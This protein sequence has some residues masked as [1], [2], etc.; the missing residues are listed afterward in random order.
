MEIEANGKK[1]VKEVGSWFLTQMS[2]GWSWESLIQLLFKQR[3]GHFTRVRAVRRIVH[4]AI[5]ILSIFLKELAERRRE[6]EEEGIRKVDAI[7]LL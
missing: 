3:E 4:G 1:L 5:V 6:R 7:G 2:Y